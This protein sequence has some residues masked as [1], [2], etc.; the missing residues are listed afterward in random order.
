M[1]SAKKGIGFGIVG[2][3]F[4]GKTHLDAAAKMRGGRVR[5]FVTSDPR[6]AKGDFRG[7]GGNFGGSGTRVDVS[8]MNVYP[9]LD[10]LL[11]DDAV[12]VV[13]ICLPSYL[14]AK[15]AERVLRA[16]KDV[17]VE[18]PIALATSEADRMIR[19]AKKSRRLLLVG[20]VLKFFP[21]FA[22]LERAIETEEW[23]KLLSL[24]LR[25]IIAKPSWSADSWFADAKRS[26]GMTVDL[27]IHDTDFMVYLFGKPR[28]V[29]SSG[30]IRDRT[31]DRIRTTY[32]YRGR[33]KPLLTA[34]AGWIN[35]ASLPFEHGYDAYFEK[36]SLHY[37]SSH[38]PVPV[39]Y[40]AKSAR[41]LKL[42]ARDGFTVELE[43]AAGAV[44]ARK[45]P[46]G[47]A[48]E[49]AAMSLAVCRAEEKSARSGKA[50]EL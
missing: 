8:R 5:A 23:G 33:G 49:I 24:H 32:H 45:V 50:V 34:E 29:S 15:T 3:G 20:Q 11:A 40:G 27:H 46:R 4:M 18:K 19:T 7:V 1:A 39:L 17:L 25:R 47:L 10:E 48:P 22:R 36:A 42:P 30:L 28:A 37:N 13:D 26:G 16:G 9:T 12:D 44:R 43:A 38:A 35:G 2:M 6:K 14:H 41:K 31:L 21:E